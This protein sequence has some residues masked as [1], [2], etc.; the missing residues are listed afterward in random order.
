[1]LIRARAMA[2]GIQRECIDNRN[3][4]D[5]AL[6]RDPLEWGNGLRNSM[7]MLSDEECRRFANAALDLP[8]DPEVSALQRPFVPQPEVVG[9]TIGATGQLLGRFLANSTRQSFR[10]WRA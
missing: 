7:E 10:L 4:V 2:S 5:A 9:Q 8:P 1:M 6:A 3:I